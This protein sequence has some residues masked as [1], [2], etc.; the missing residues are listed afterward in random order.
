MIFTKNDSSITSDTTERV[1]REN[2]K[3]N[4][5][6]FLPDVFVTD[7][8][9][10]TNKEFKSNAGKQIIIIPEYLS[11]Y[12]RKSDR[13]IVSIVSSMPRLDQA[14]YEFW[15]D[16]YYHI[17]LE[18]LVVDPNVVEPAKDTERLLF[19]PVNVSM[20]FET[21]IERL[22]NSISHMKEYG[23]GYG[24][25]FRHINSKEDLREVFRSLYITSK[26][27]NYS[28]LEHINMSIKTN[29]Y[30]DVEKFFDV[31]ISNLGVIITLKR[32][33]TNLCLKNSL[34]TILVFFERLF[35]CL[36]RQYGESIIVHDDYISIARAAYLKVLRYVSIQEY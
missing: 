35:N 27:D 20:L 4:K 2:I 14:D 22:Y 36:I 23:V 30:K 10:V 13:D 8:A 12:F 26:E 19:A 5:K 21:F 3:E 18:S 24:I 29:G 25:G 16:F 28:K 33:F 15:E 34:C 17:L 9:S 31:E 32:G 11:H 6:F 7:H 1:N